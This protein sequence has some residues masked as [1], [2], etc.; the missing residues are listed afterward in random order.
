MQIKPISINPW[1]PKNLHPHT[2]GDN[3]IMEQ[4]CKEIDYTVKS[5]KTHNCLHKREKEKVKNLI[6]LRYLSVLSK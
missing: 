1:S 6:F 3:H 2:S 5:V 4:T